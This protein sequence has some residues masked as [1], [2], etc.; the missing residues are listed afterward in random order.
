VSGLARKMA[1]ARRQK[2]AVRRDVHL[3]NYVVPMPDP[4][5]K[6]REIKRHERDVALATDRMAAS[7]ARVMAALAATGYNHPAVVAL[8]ARMD[9]HAVYDRGDP[10]A[11]GRRGWMSH[12]RGEPNRPDKGKR[13]GS[14][15]R[16]ACQDVLAG[17]LPRWS[18]SDHE[19]FTNGRLYYCQTCAEDFNKSDIRFGTPERCTVMPGDDE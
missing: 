16:T 11:E 4:G 14:C 5:A 18:M 15:N 3:H 6:A 12:P 7:D 1:R 17:Q 13:D 19:H 8:R 2:V 10:V 9:E